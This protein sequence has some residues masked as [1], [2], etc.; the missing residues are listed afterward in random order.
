MAE[1]IATVAVELQPHADEAT[2]LRGRASSAVL[3]TVAVA[4]AAAREPS[5]SI[6]A[7]WARTSYRAGGGGASVW[8]DG[9]VLA[10]AGAAFVNGVAA[11]ALDYDDVNL[12]VGGHPSALLV[13]ALVAAGEAADADGTA[14]LDAYM[15]GIHVSASVAAGLDLAAHY[16][17]GWHATTTIGSIGA[18]AAVA[19][20]TGLTVEETCDA[21]CT[22]ASIAAG[23]RENFGSMVKP[24]HVGVAA[25]NVILACELAGAGFEARET[26]LDGPLGFLVLHAADAPVQAAAASTA[27]R[28]GLRTFATLNSVKK[29]P[30]CYQTHRALDAAVDLR[31]K[32]GTRV[33]AARRVVVTVDP[34]SDNSLIHA[35]PTEP[36]QGRF[37]MQYTVAAALH[38]GRV[39]FDTFTEQALQRQEVRDLMARVAVEHEPIP[40]VGAEAFPEHYAV[41]HVECED[42]QW[43]AGRA[44]VA[45][46]DP[47]A[48][49]APRELMDKVS[50]CLRLAD[51]APDAEAVAA[52]VAR[53]VAGEPVRALTGAL[54]AARLR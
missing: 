50:D 17:K 52:A 18:A 15:V 47:E 39:G 11:H 30:C 14:L 4:L 6:A 54:G 16:A 48:P 20:L 35:D 13:P 51:P 23:S 8:G 5:R 36:A 32:F 40:P 41:V 29:Y 27:L 3:D 7:E 34:G 1:E 43:L 22:A 9:D 12:A 19:R 38:D 37:S 10:P 28:K 21:V 49:L 31:R 44:D 2:E 24:L 26:A 42:G 33:A 45:R 53:L 46:G 25:A